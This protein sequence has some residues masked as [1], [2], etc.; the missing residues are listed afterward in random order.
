ASRMDPS[1]RS[2]PGSR[3]TCGSRS[4]RGNCAA[5]W[6]RYPGSPESLRAR[7]KRLLVID[8][9]PKVTAVFA[10][11]F[12]GRYLVETAS[13][14]A[15]GVAAVERNRPDAVLLDIS[16]PEMNGLQVLRRIKHLDERI[17]VI[18]VTGNSEVAVAE[19]ALRD[20]AFA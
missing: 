19:A 3:P 10:E 16:M 7:V 15:D 9:D 12:S 8:D 2:G 5:R 20:G 6:H 1:A 17:P 13:S 18:M 4:I 11:F 14:G